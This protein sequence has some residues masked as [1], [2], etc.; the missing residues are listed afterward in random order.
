M[1]DLNPSP[2]VGEEPAPA[3]AGVPEEPAPECFSRGADEG[4]AERD[5]FRRRSNAKSGFLNPERALQSVST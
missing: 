4:R 5:T 2:L 3:K 1:P